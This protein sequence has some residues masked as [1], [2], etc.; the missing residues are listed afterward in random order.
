[1]RHRQIWGLTAV[2]R[3]WR[4]TPLVRVGAGEPAAA[5]MPA[6]AVNRGDLSALL[7]ILRKLAETGAAC[8]SNADL[9]R[10][11]SLPRGERGRQRAQYLL[12]RLAGEKRIAIESRGRNAPRIVT[13]LA[14]VRGCGKSTEEIR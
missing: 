8:P 12:H 11:L 3:P 4:V 14:A 7:R 1:M 13:I 10:L 9:A 5:D 2:C 6:R